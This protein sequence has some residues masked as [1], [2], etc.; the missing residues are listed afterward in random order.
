MLVNEPRSQRYIHKANE[1]ADIN[2]FDQDSLID[3]HNTSYIHPNTQIL[4]AP[5]STSQWSFNGNTTSLTA[6]S[7]NIT[8]FPRTQYPDEGIAPTSLS[9]YSISGNQSALYN[10]TY[11]LSHGSCKPSET[12]QWGFSYIFLFMVSIFNFVWACIMVGMWLDTRSGS[13]LYKSGRRP[14]LLRS[15]VE[16][17]AA[18]R[19]E[20]GEGVEELEEEELIERLR[21][22]GGRLAVRKEELRVRRVDSGEMDREGGVRKR[23]WR[24]SLTSGS[25]L[26]RKSVV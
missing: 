1:L 8:R 16:Y 22:G 5:N 6:P 3:F 25:T 12:Y 15:I 19:E 26:D 23:G 4:V 10:A 13:R 20:V 14:G 9:Y 7:L 2:S 24:R 21:G 17:A 18:I 11:M